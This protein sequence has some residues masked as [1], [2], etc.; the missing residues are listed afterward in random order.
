MAEIQKIKCFRT[1]MELN[2]YELGDYPKLETKLSTWDKIY[3]RWIPKA[4]VYDEERKCLLIPSGIQTSMVEHI[5]GRP[6]EIE[7]DVDSY[8]PMSIRMLAKPRDDLQRESIS[9]LSGKGKYANY[10]SY[11]QMV[12]N[13]DTGKGKTFTAIALMSIK[14]LK[15]LIIV[16][17]AKIKQ[18][19][20]DKLQEYTDIDPAAITEIIG[21]PKCKSIINNPEKY[22]RSRIFITTHDTLRSFGNNYGWNNVHLLFEALKVG[23]KIYDE[24]H[25]EFQ[26]IVKVD[27][28]SNTKF[29]Y[30][31]TATFG[32]SDLSENF[33][34]NTCFK[35]IPKFE[36]KKQEDYQGKRYITYIAVFYRSNPTIAQIDRMKNKYGFNRNKY[37]TYQLVHDQYFFTKVAELVQL[38]VIKKEAKTLLLLTT[39][40]GIEDIKDYLHGLYPNINIAVWHSKIKKEEKE[41]AIENADLI[42][43][44]VKSLGVG[45]DIPGLRAVINTESFKSPIVTEQI[46]GR[47]RPLAD[48]GTCWYIELIDRA[49]STLKNQQKSR[50]KLI[51]SLV[52][53]VLYVK[54]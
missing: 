3:F 22:K 31:L 51:R 49:F 28:Y 37:A 33:V 14:R 19:W 25:Q 35:T 2:D 38:T 29:T 54:D 15:S 41:N 53:K 21:S 45:A 6:V 32:R 13:L 7:Y 46:V 26:N 17:T 11:S 50:E 52:G 8:E 12:L 24:T 23:V 4:Y 16:S 30:Y 47:L 1:H 27:C 39:I 43:S 18:Q 9:F 34:F 40:E 5:T 42:I 20:I 48:G 10:S 36:Q 44:T